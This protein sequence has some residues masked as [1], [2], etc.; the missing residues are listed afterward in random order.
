MNKT[1]I[2][3]LFLIVIILPLILA[4]CGRKGDLYLPKKEIPAKQNQVN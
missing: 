4:S 2:S 1:K 3:K